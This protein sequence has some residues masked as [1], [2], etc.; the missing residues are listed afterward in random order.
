MNPAISALK[1][2]AFTQLR[3][4]QDALRDQGVKLI[5]FG[6]GDPEDETPPFIRQALVEAITPSGRYPTAA[7]LPELRAAIATWLTRRYDLPVDPERHVIPANGA[8]EAIYNLAPLLLDDPANRRER[9]VVAVPE[10][11]YW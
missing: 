4:R 9:Q 8:K 5:N 6:V 1:P 3:A 11:A 10:L 7:G 2:Y